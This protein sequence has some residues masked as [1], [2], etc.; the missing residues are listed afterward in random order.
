MKDLTTQITIRKRQFGE[1]LEVKCRDLLTFPSRKLS[2]MGAK[3][4][5]LLA[6]N[7]PV[8]CPTKPSVTVPLWSRRSVAPT[9]G[10]LESTAS[11]TGV[12]EIAAPFQPG[13]PEEFLQSCGGGTASSRFS[14]RWANPTQTCK[15]YVTISTST[16]G[17]HAKRT[18]GIR[19]KNGHLER[20][21]GAMQWKRMPD[22]SSSSREFRCRQSWYETSSRSS[23]RWSRGHPNPASS[24]RDL[25]KKTSLEA[26]KRTRHDIAES[27]WNDAEMR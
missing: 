12:P 11:R 18:V 3:R 21:N 14:S 10:V 15:R 27:R 25:T 24:R 23:I 22:P 20:K 16:H 1:V 13:S 7:L 26:P 8:R 17:P 2:T 9:S 6:S 4:P 5:T 19:A